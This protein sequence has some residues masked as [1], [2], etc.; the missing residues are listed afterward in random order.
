M[1]QVTR[2]GAVEHRIAVRQVDRRDVPTSQFAPHRRRLAAHA[3]QHRDVGRA[4]PNEAALRVVETGLFIVQQRDDAF[5]AAR[6]EC[7]QA[8]VRIRQSGVEHKGQRGAA[9]GSHHETFVP[10][11]RVDRHERQRVVL[12]RRGQAGGAEHEGA[13]APALT[14]IPKRT[15]TDTRLGLT[16]HMVHRTDQC[17]RRT[18]VRAQHV[19][20]TNGR[21][22]HREVAVDVGAAKAVDGL[23]R[24]ADQQQGRGRAVVGD[25]VQPV[26]DARLDGRGVLELVDQCDRVLRQHA[27]P[28]PFGVRAVAGRVERIVEPGQHVGKAEAAGLRLQLGQARGDA[29]RRVRAQMS[30]RHGQG[31]H[32]LHQALEGREVIGQF[33]AAVG[34]QRINHAGRRE[35][36]VALLQVKN[37][38]RIVVSPGGKRF[39]P[40]LEVLG[41]QLLPVERA[42][43]VG[44]LRIE[45][46]SHIT[47]PMCPA[48]LQGRERF[49]ALAR[50]PLDQL[51]EAARTGVFRQ[52]LADQLARIFGQRI[53]ISPHAQ[54][55]VELRA[56]QRVELLA[57]VVLRR[58]DLH[59]AFVGGEFLVEQATAVERVLAQHAL[60]PGV[61]G[62]HGRVVHA[63]GRQA[64]P[65]RGAAAGRAFR[66]VGQQIDQEGVA[67]VGLGFAAKAARGF[68]QAR[69]DAVGQLTRGGAREGHH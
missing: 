27:G 20:A 62:V 45:P 13:I 23:F 67:V 60:A 58:L 30:G 55:H 28:Q 40:R 7:A 50:Q 33:D 14:L 16:E 29:R 69:S 46:G 42:A 10:A 26:E 4:Q 48:K 47:C 1:Q 38:R 68:K 11:L 43:L 61:D 8:G 21:A 63:L 34:R 56:G 39:E 9:P 3:H 54:C 5:G 41:S 49:P 66:V 64:Q 57:P 24:V 35:A 51:A 19:V 52:G 31:F 6:R 36:D 32:G 12:S 65:P 44:H 15:P 22:P 17:R 18:V 59:R 2:L 25:A 53:D 37:I